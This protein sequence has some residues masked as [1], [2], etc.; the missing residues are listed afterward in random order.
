M[1]NPN[2]YAGFNSEQRVPYIEFAVNQII[3]ISD[4]VLNFLNPGTKYTGRFLYKHGNIMTAVIWSE[5]L[6]EFEYRTNDVVSVLYIEHNSLLGFNARLTKVK[7]ATAKE[8]ADIG[9]MPVEINNIYK[10]DKYIIDFIP[11]TG[12][13]K[14]QRR[15][16]FRMPL[17]TE[18]YYKIIKSGKV[19]D[20]DDNEL[21]YDSEKAKKTKKYADKGLLEKDDGYRKFT[22]AE[23]SAGGFKF[24]TK[25]EIEDGTYLDC[26]LV[27]NDEAL[28]AVIQILGLKPDK[29]N[30]QLYEARAVFYKMSDSVR[31]R[32]IKYIFAQQRQSRSK[33]VKK[34][35]N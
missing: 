25:M 15:E 7:K 18:I 2:I 10:Y 6:K 8:E 11:L 35:N 16:F 12:S 14:Q 27:A 20:I 5:T 3:M 22:T 24:K 17:E 1:I 32:V 13:E 19:K 28:P 34:S 26:K 4:S 29:D 23:I 30:P 21:K 9:S 31:D 33:S